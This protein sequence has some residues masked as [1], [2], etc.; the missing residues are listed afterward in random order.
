ML[1]HPIS[2]YKSYLLFCDII[3]LNLIC[4][5]VFRAVD[6]RFDT[7]LSLFRLFEEDQQ[8][9][10]ALVYTLAGNGSTLDLH[11]HSVVLLDRQHHLG[12]LALSSDLLTDNSAV[13]HFVAFSSRKTVQAGR[14]FDQH[15]EPKSHQK[16]YQLHDHRHDDEA[17]SLMLRKDHDLTKSD[18]AGDE[19]DK[20]HQQKDRPSLMRTDFLTYIFVFFFSRSSKTHMYP[21]NTRPDK[22]DITEKDI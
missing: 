1:A 21:S 17:Y 14:I 10:F 6:D 22:R 3:L 5:D 13:L 16:E 20:D 19:K 11:L 4:I 2:F 7:A 9:P 15:S 18:R 12:V 8:H